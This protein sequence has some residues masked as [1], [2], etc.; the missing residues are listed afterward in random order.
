MKP[1]E[2]CLKK[3]RLKKIEPDAERVAGELDTAKEELERARSSYMNRN[4]DEAAT[5]A[6][7]AMLRCARA[8]INSRGYRDTNLYGLCIGLQ[9][10]LVEGGELSANVVKEIRTAKDIKD[11]VYSGHRASY[12]DARQLLQWAQFLA[13]DVF[14]LVALPGFEAGEISTVIPDPPERAERAEPRP[15]TD[16]DPDRQP[17]RNHSNNRW[18]S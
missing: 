13:R 14:K 11:A 2:D 9:E 1:F 10:L 8:A 4:W 12:R 16:R 6:C 15:R 18:A 3:G 17:W 7:F 5:Q